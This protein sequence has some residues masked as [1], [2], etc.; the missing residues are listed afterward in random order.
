MSSALTCLFCALRR[1]FSLGTRLCRAL[2][3]CGLGLGA[4]LVAKA[5][6]VVVFNEIHY[7]PTEG[8][9]AGEFIE[10]INQ[11]AT[12]INLSGWRIDGGVQFQFPPKTILAGGQ[13]LVIASQPAQVA[14]KAGLAHVFG[15]WTGN[16]SNGGERLELLAQNDRRMD[17]VAYSDAPPWPVGADGSGFTLVKRAAN[18]D[19]ASPDSWT[20]SA[21]PGG[22]PGR[23]ESSILPESKVP[24][25]KGSLLAFYPFDE[26]AQDTSGN[27][28]NGDVSAV[29]VNLTTDGSGY[30]GNAYRFT[31]QGFI[32]LPININPSLL[33]QV[34]IGAWVKAATLS[35][36][37]RHEILSTDNGGY[38]RALTLDSRSGPDEAG[39]ARYGAFGGAS[40]GLVVGPQARTTD[41]WVFIAAVFDSEKLRTTLYVRTNTYTGAATHGSSGS[42]VRVGAHPQG[43]EFFN[44]W[45]DNVF[46]FNRALSSNEIVTIR[47]Q[48]AAGVMSVA[49]NTVPDPPARNLPLL[50]L[51]PFDSGHQDVSGNGR[52]GTTN[53]LVSLTTGGQGREGESYRFSGGGINIPIDLGPRTRP[54]LTLGAWVKPVAVASPYRRRVLTTST[55]SFDRGLHLDSRIGETE[56]GVTRYAAPGGDGVGMIAGRPASTN[57]GW[58]FCAVV[59]DARNAS[60]LLMV[61][62]E[63]FAGEATQNTTVTAL[64]IGRGPSGSEPFHGLIDNVFAFSRALSISELSGI[65]VGGTNAILALNVSAASHSPTNLPPVP[66]AP[67]V[68]LN[69]LPAAGAGPLRVELATSTDQSLDLP[70]LIV[71]FVSATLTRDVVVPARRVLPGEHW[72]VDLPTVGPP[73]AKGDQILLYDETKRRLLDAQVVQ[74]WPQS[75][76]PDLQGNWRPTAVASLG[77]SNP[78][79]RLL[80]VGFNEIYYHA[81]A[82]YL[83][84]RQ[85]ESSDQWI[86]IHNR[87]SED[88]KLGGWKIGGDVQYTFPAGL[89]L[90]TG[91]YLVIANDLTRFE[92]VW[93]TSQALGPWQ[94]KLSANEGKLWME[95]QTGQR[96]D[97]VVY[98]DAGRWP[99]YADGGGSSLELRSPRADHLS[100]EVWAASDETARSVWQTYTYRGL[101]TQNTGYNVGNDQFQELV[102]G[103]LD[104]GEILLDDV[105]VT[106]APGGTP[107][108]LIQNGSFDGDVVGKL[109]AKWR[110]GGNHAAS[111]RTRVEV[112][113]TN[114]ANQCLH[115]VATGATDYLLNH[116]ETTLKKGT[117]VARVVAGREYEISFRAKWVAGTPL[118]NTRLYFNFLQRTHVIATPSL[119]GTP[120]MQNSRFVD[121]LGPTF[122]GLQHS[123]LVPTPKQPVSVQVRAQDPDGVENL[124]LRFAVNGAEWQKVLMSP[125]EGAMWAG[126]IPPQKEGARVQFYVEAI[127]RLGRAADF[128]AEGPASRALYTVEA[129]PSSPTTIHRLRVLTT[130][131]DA[132]WLY[133]PT[134]RMSNERVGATVIYDDG[135][136]FYDV[137][138]RLKGSAFGRNNDTETGCNVE[139]DPAHKFRGVHGT[140][141]L[142]RS[143]GGAGREILGKY[144]F[145]QAAGGVGSLFDDVTYVQMPRAQDTGLALI[146]LSR[147]TEDFLSSQWKNGGE[148]SVWNMDLLYSPNGTTTGNP[149]APKLNYP[150]N[151]DFGQPDIQDLGDDKE[152]YRWN[153]QLRN[154]R[155]RDDYAPLI[156]VAKAFSLTGAQLDGATQEAIDVEQWLRHFAVHTLV[157]SVDIY[158]RYW[159]HNLRLYERPEDGRVLALPWDLDSSFTIDVGAPLWD[160]SN[161][162]GSPVRFAKVI[163]LPGNARR[164][165]SHVLDLA[166]TVCTPGTAVRWADHY[167]TLCQQ[168]FTPFS[169]FLIQ[170]RRFALG[171]MTRLTNFFRLTTPLRI[172]ATNNPVLLSGHAGIEVRSFMINRQLVPTTWTGSSRGPTNFTL[173][174]AA[175]PGSNFLTLEAFDNAGNTLSNY[176]RHITVIYQGEPPPPTGLRINEWMASNSHTLAD[177][178]DGGFEDWFELYN[179]GNQAVD[180][181]G[182]VL[183]DT[184]TGVGGFTVPTHGVYVLPA[185]GFLI[186]WADDEAGQNSESLRD[187]HVNF[188]LAQG[189][190]AIT[191]R[192]PSGKI[193][194]TVVFGAQSLD[195]TEGRFP[196]GA[197][198]LSTLTTPTPGRPNFY[199]PA[200]EIPALRNVSLVS[201]SKI[202]WEVEGFAGY[203]YRLEFKDALTDP[204]WQPVGQTLMGV[205]GT[206]RFQ[207]DV[208]TGP[209][210]F[211]RVVAE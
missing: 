159:N 30:E 117:T 182:Y 29:G 73:L 189:G 128:P 100:P 207:E 206:L 12:D 17:V 18:L 160:T 50:I 198:L 191:L 183:S 32:D 133:E 105:Q 16:L 178:A 176:T 45:I 44:G 174:V 155:D 129:Y 166:N 201:G 15:P 74:V 14:A 35:S 70:P 58:I 95:D 140:I 196:D 33:P 204:V 110:I 68:V 120:G 104:A 165:Y 114:P 65:R 199:R 37:A 164:F 162:I 107:I 91:K 8:D 13:T 193:V 121:N 31:G 83:D 202:V 23:T 179:P 42:F 143:G 122:E 118:L 186:V 190:E 163:D 93:P 41:G 94:G 153:F 150:Y 60:T 9:V 154:H 136:V 209:Q 5:E 161:G 109:P 138:L 98:R 158:L 137:G 69:E 90:S 135:E 22:T 172:E 36:P 127:D 88:A 149:E 24:E 157:G 67:P 56:S 180:L 144:F 96:A 97:E 59:Y 151:H 205:G 126:Q 26:G 49:T 85:V 20:V 43:I 61:D 62:D 177:P 77:A 66:L 147:N 141:S 116:A 39:V 171:Q 101:A 203:F 210:R 51:L 81:P 89:V 139:F 185:K 148:G 38:D 80:E 4:A 87:G 64:S 134:N 208:G 7:H 123:P 181:G 79:A 115:L 10:L 145:N 112:D 187:L 57:Q 103:L 27:A 3:F 92:A 46:L 52:V 47:T 170:R 200:P 25:A 142:E 102:I 169:D 132:A 175:Q 11:N 131:A 156:R 71:S 86:E 75:R 168:N 167:G 113:P 130:A 188:K 124:S 1:A 55:R 197:P 194:D 99:V 6:S 40:T 84:G 53:G 125:I 63:V 184:T 78:A 173:Q 21:L 28:R 48:G 152:A 108:S 195:V 106:E 19:S 119:A 34:T 2:L 111:G 192:D 146:A 82:Q 54:Q 72:I 76:L 211:Y